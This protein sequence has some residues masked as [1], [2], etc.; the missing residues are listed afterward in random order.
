M[1]MQDEWLQQGIRPRGGPEAASTDHK[2][3]FDAWLVSVLCDM[4]RLTTSFIAQIKVLALNAMQ[5]L[6]E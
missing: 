1:A 5:H 3:P 6:R 2:D 4:S